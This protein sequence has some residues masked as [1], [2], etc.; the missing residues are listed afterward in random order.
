MKIANLHNK[1][2]VAY[3]LVGLPGSGKSTWIR[4]VNAAGEY[5]VISSDDKIDAHA[6]ENG[7]TYSDVFDSYIKQATSAMNADFKEAVANNKNIIWDQTN[8]SSKKRKGILQQLPKNYKKIAVVFQ[9]ADDELIRRL[10]KRSK[11]EGKTIPMGIVYSMAKSFEMPTT[12]E[13]FNEII[14]V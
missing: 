1:Q 5:V 14:R 10:E 12:A 6:K 3:V 4:S 2:P 11:D 13:G 8:M 9:I 7:K